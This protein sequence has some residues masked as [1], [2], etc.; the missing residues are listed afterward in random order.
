MDIKNSLPLKHKLY[1]ERLIDKAVEADKKKGIVPE[2]AVQIAKLLSLEYEKQGYIRR[3]VLREMLDIPDSVMII[4]YAFLFHNVKKGSRRLRHVA[5]EEQSSDWMSASDFC[6]FNIRGVGK[7]PAETG[8]IISAIKLLP[9]LRV[10][11]IHLAP[12]FEC[13]FGIIYCQ[14]SFYRINKE[15]VNW[16]YAEGGITP[17]EQMQFFIDCIH[18]LGKAVGFDITPHTSWLSKLRV[19]RPELF[20]WIRLDSGKERL[21]GNMAIDVQYGDDFQ[22]K[23][24]DFVRNIAD[25]YKK[26]YGIADLDAP[27]GQYWLS[28]KVLNKINRKLQ[29]KGYYSVPPHTWN[30]LSVPDFMKFSHNLKMPIWR[31]LDAHGEEQGKHAL[32]LHSSFYMHKGLYANKLPAQIGEDDSLEPVAVNLTVLRFFKEYLREVIKCYHFDFIRMDYVDHIFDNVEVIN[33]EEI[34]VNEMFTPCE[35]KSVIT[36]LRKEYPG[37]GFQA[38]HLGYDSRVFEKAG[39]NLIMGGE[40]GFPIN[41]LYIKDI[42]ELLFRQST[43]QGQQCRAAFAVD[44]HDMAHPLFFGK[45]LALREGTVGFLSRLMLARFA[46][47]GKYRRPKYEVIGSQDMSFGIHRANNRPESIVWGNHI[48]AYKAYHNIEDSYEKIKAEIPFYRLVN[49]VVSNNHVGWKLYNKRLNHYL[50]GV[51]PI[52]T[53]KGGEKQRMEN[54]ED[55]LRLSLNDEGTYSIHYIFATDTEEINFS[56]G[57]WNNSLLN[58]SILGREIVITMQRRGY[59]LIK[60]LEGQGEEYE[61]NNSGRSYKR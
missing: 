39:F 21:H 26:K 43:D 24:A 37:L 12:F 42:M 7:E 60:L 18:L 30:G 11:G 53:G 14:N 25:R 22:C 13:D 33:G 50:L 45:E 59:V 49:Y 27:D 3:A 36:S 2:E 52:V 31:Y 32:W 38:D 51:V 9:C 55:V 6:F 47:V 34:P 58:T 19:D 40:V 17:L 57:D 16:Q 48:K 35:I 61:K 44:T 46:A 5:A 41:R 15:I 29:K 23:C 28:T 54:E 1:W 56:G 10:N 8:N 4:F 20:R